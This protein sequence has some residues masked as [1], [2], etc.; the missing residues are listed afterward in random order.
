MQRVSTVLHIGEVDA[1]ADE[2]SVIDSLNVDK[3]KSARVAFS[4]WIC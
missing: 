2:S 4:E 1:T 3:T